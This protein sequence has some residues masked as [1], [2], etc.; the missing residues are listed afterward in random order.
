[1]GLVRDPRYEKAIAR[2]GRADAIHGQV[3]LE[4]EAP[5][6]FHSASAVEHAYDQLTGYIIG[7][8]RT[9]NDALFIFDPKLVGVG[10]DGEQIF[11]VRYRGDVRSPK[12]ELDKD[13]FTRLGPYPFNRDSATTLLAHMRALNRRLLTAEELARVFGPEMFA[14]PGRG[15]VSR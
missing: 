1:M 4:Y 12:T 3:I 5:R 14:R 7:E 8:A 6:A 10:F 2:A 11:F 13:E 9:R 15:P